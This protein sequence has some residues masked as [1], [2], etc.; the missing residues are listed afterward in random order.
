MSILK[1]KTNNRERLLMDQGWRFHLGEIPFPEAKTVGESYGWGWAKAGAFQGAARPEFNDSSWRQVD[2]PHDWAVEG[3]F[4]LDAGPSHGY[5]PT[6]VAWYRKTFFLPARHEGR[7]LYLE[8]E[9]IFRNATVFLNGHRLGHEPSGYISFH[10]DITDQAIYG[11]ENVLAVHVDATE[12]EGWWYEG[13]GI[14]RHVWLTITDELHFAPLGVFVTADLSRDHRHADLEIISEIV[15][16][17]EGDAVAEISLTVLDPSG[18]KVAQAASPISIKAGQEQAI[19]SGL[20]LEEPRLW[21]VDSPTLYQLKAAVSVNHNRVDEVVTSFGV[22]SILFDP[23]LGFLL[24]GKPLKIKGTSNHQDH[25][26]VGVAVPDSLFEFRIRK[27]KEM[28]ANAWRC[29]HNPPAPAF[30]DACDRLGMMVMDETRCMNSTLDGRRQLE[31][32]V[33]RD[34]NH[35]SV[36]IWSLGNEETLQGSKMGMR[37]IRSM[38]RIVRCLDKSRP[39]TLAMNGC[40]GEPVSPVLD[41]MGC[42]Y[43][44]SKYDEYHRKFPGQPMLGSETCAALSMRGEYIDDKS[45]GIYSAYDINFPEFGGTAENSWRAVSDRD[46]VAGAFPWTGFDYRGEPTPAGWPCVSSNFGILDTCGFPKDS[47]YYYKSCWSSD[48]VLHIFP[49][50]NWSGREG[51]EVPVW[52]FSNC[53]EVELFLNGISQGRKKMPVNGHL[54][55][56]VKYVPGTLLAKAYRKG[57]LTMKN[58]VETTGAPAKLA[59][60]PERK[61]ICANGEDAAIIKV[62]VLDEA[63]RVVPDADNMIRFEIEGSARFLGAGNGNSHCHESDKETQHRVYH[64]LCQVLLLASDKPGLIT[65]KAASNG[66]RTAT[67]HLKAAKTDLRPSLPAVDPEARIEFARTGIALAWVGKREPAEGWNKI[68]FIESEWKTVSL[69]G[70]LV[71]PSPAWIRVRFNVPAGFA[72]EGL[73]LDLGAVHDYDDT[74]LNGVRLGSFNPGNTSP[75]TAWLIRRRYLLPKGLLKP[76]RENVLAIHAWNRRTDPNASTII[77]GP[78]RIRGVN[79]T[80]LA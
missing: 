17:G 39:V 70:S 13:A 19:T 49:H 12:G 32:M 76:G 22:R 20:K 45:R 64:G 9:G 40:W 8:F 53:D 78:S 1:G 50:W 41:V 63:G 33:R 74:W 37:I 47:F 65:F 80:P 14:Y 57:R 59:L 36:I 31:S 48:D 35:P 43:S 18:R 23:D 51:K 5:L 15:N 72:T 38:K 34:R 52:C 21:S 69:G 42:N 11:D 10:Y 77:P 6:G 7:R 62:A 58:K 79:Y 30:L 73:E 44:A 28:G 16:A 26:G 25:A 3:I 54:E 68:D 67:L 56:Q 66:L 61:T 75:E 71:L 24:N 29:A 4:S 55:W 2:L 60:Y 46:F 27:L